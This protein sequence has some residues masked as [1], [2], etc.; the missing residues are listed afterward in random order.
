MTD[1]DILTAKEVANILRVH[2]YSVVKWIREGKL[3][4]FKV[5]GGPGRWR[6]KRE[7]LEAFMESEN[8]EETTI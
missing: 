2:D 4:G 1:H 8:D 5:G 7:D 6:V 3:K